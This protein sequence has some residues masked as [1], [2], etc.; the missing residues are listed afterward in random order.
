MESQ[1]SP[2]VVRHLRMAQ[3]GCVLLALACVWLIRVGHSKNHGAITPIH[4]F[5]LL[6][7]IYCAVAGF[8]TQRA[9]AKKPSRPSRP[10]NGST[11]F[12][13]WRA[14][15]LIRLATATSVA[16]WAAV[17]SVSGGPIWIAYWL[18]AVGVLLLVIWRPGE[19]PVADAARISKSV[20]S[21]HTGGARQ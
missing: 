8:T 17:L 15:H 14:G 6:A 5:I 19:L 4:W 12:T 10:K 7:A 18:A 3:S 2:M 11:P 9:L 21:K 13:R 20:T 1:S 16:T